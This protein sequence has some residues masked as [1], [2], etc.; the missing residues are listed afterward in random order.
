MQNSDFWSRITRLHWSHTSPV[1]SCIQNIVISTRI[2]SLYGSQP[3]S[4]VLC[5]QNSDI[6]NQNYKSLLVPSPHLSF[7]AFKIAC[8]SN[9]N[10]KSVWVPALI[11]DFVHVNTATLWPELQV[12]VGPRPHLWV[13]CMQNSDFMNKNYKPPVWV[14]DLTC[15]CCALQNGVLTYQNN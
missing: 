7:C 15:G 8:F 12:C 14:P 1:I 13:L 4:V 9:Q 2:N 10:N 3:S 6:Y 11:C 5:I